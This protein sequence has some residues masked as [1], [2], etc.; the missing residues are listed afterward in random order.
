MRKVWGIFTQNYAERRR[1]SH[2]FHSVLIPH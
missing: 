2:R 1:D